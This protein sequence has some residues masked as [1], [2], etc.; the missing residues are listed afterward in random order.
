MMREWDVAGLWRDFLVL[1]VHTSAAE[2]NQTEENK[3]T[4]SCY[5][6]S[7]LV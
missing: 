4:I 3:D 5:L 6:G 7:M 1:W 2:F